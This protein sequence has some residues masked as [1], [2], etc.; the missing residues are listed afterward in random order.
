MFLSDAE[1]MV[2]I[3]K[4]GIALITHLVR[5]V[6]RGLAR[7]SHRHRVVRRANT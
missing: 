4:S 1:S 7:I 5:L 3:V 2:R 6:G